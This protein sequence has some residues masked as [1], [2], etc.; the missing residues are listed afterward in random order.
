MI[1]TFIF[2]AVA[3]AAA[4]GWIYLIDSGKREGLNGSIILYGVVIGCLMDLG[5]GSE[6]L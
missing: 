5:P 6:F 1:G 2:V 4:A 3:A